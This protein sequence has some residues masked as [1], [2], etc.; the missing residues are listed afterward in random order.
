MSPG[1]LAA[2]YVYFSQSRTKGGSERRPRMKAD[3]HSSSGPV[4]KDEKDLGLS[5]LKTIASSIPHCDFAAFDL[6]GTSTPLTILLPAMLVLLLPLLSILQPSKVLAIVCLFPTGVPLVDAPNTCPSESLLGRLF[7]IRSPAILV[8]SLFLQ[9]KSQPLYVVE[10]S[11]E[12]MVRDKGCWV[13]VVAGS[14]QVAGLYMRSGL[15]C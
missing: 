13:R 1:I 3:Y 15:S 7:I 14:L 12:F 6:P 8:V 5:E 9:S 11:C 10:M 4:R 2:V